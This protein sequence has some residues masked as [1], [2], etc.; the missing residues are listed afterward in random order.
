LDSALNAT[1]G[2]DAPD[3]HGRISAAD[4]RLLV[5][6]VPTNEELVIAQETAALMIS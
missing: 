4:S 1:H 6:V 2:A 5:L 3:I